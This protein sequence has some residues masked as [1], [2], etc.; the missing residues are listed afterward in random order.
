MGVSV[1]PGHTQFARTPS[2]AQSIAS[3]RVSAAT[4][5]FETLRRL[6]RQRHERGL[7]GDVDD[8]AAARLEQRRERLAR[9]QRTEQVHLEVATEVVDGQ[10]VDREV[11]R[12]DPRRVD[13]HVE[14]A[15]PAPGPSPRAGRALA[16]GPVDRVVS[17]RS[18]TYTSAPDAR[19]MSLH[20]P[21]IPRAPP[22]TT[23]TLPARLGIMARSG[24]ARP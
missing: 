18:T 5:P 14:A 17:P 19:S 21:P 6:H 16:V 1:N 2:S 10:L 22:V 15:V 24:A 11:G 20:A 8:G 3:E 9:V 4:P 13:E 7:R 23:A 12:D